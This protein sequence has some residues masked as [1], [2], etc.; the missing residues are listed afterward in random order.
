MQ[1]ETEGGGYSEE[2]ELL[3]SCLIP[4]KGHCTVPFW[5][6]TMGGEELHKI[7]EPKKFK[8]ESEERKDFHQLFGT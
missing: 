6:L 8:V 7:I 2:M 3:C 1:V 4:R 5:A